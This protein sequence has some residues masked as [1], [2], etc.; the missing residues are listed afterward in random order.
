VTLVLD[1]LHLLTDP[2]VLDGLDYMLRNTGAE[3]I[4]DNSA[5]TGYLVAEVLNT[6]L[7]GLL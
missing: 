4:S 5:L 3:L 1:D 2:A 7:I 6:R